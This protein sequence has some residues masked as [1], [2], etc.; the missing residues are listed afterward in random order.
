MSG[1]AGRSS[2]VAG[3]QPCGSDVQIKLLERAMTNDVLTSGEELI[4]EAGIEGIGSRTAERLDAVGI[5]SIDQLAEAEPA[6]LAESLAPDYPKL[7]AE[8]LR[9]RVDHWVRLAQERLRPGGEPSTRGHVFLLTLWADAD[10][11]PVRSRFG[12]RSPDE[13][14]SEERSIETVGWSPIAFA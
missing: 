1:S 13:P 10:G 6:R 2:G 5:A 3:A 4:K 12:Y 9:Q 11:R 14:T 7:R 8:T